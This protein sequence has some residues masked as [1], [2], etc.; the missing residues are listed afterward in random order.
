MILFT[1][2]SAIIYFTS[3]EKVI[4]VDLRSVEPKVV[5]EALLPLDSIAT[6]NISTTKDFNTDNDFPPLFGAII[7]LS[8][9]E[10][11]SEVLAQ[12]S[13]GLYVGRK[14]RG[15][16]RKTYNLHIE[17]DGKIYTSV[18]TMPQLVKLEKIN[19]YP[20]PAFDYPVPQIVFQDPKG[21]D[22]Y[23]RAKLY[24]NQTRMDIGGETID[25]EQR[26]GV[27]IERVLPVFDNDQ[28]NSRKLE[29]GDIVHVEFQCLD[30]GA[31]TFFDT[32]AQMG[33][34]LNNPT[35]NIQ[36]GALGYFS[37]YAVDHMQIVA[38]WDW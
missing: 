5:I 2:F 25:D 14:I 36:G 12:N 15:R 16:E 37:T 13:D 4:D 27:L 7:T 6:V 8:D 28:E 35:S 33:M 10:G 20:I 3:C 24:L 34:S 19:L 9:S 30:K 22:N 1:C 11:N 17:I 38:D 26:D 29:K 23:Y 32:Y 31:F 21:E 18:S